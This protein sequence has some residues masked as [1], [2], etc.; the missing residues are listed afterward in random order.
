[1]TDLT[2]MSDIIADDLLLDR[3]GARLDAGS[4]PV[5]VLLGALAA[6]ADTPL[7][8]RTVRRKVG[9][10]HRYVGALA[11]LAVAASGAGVAAAVS[12]PD[13]GLSQADRLRIEQKM[14]QNARSGAPS[15]LLSRLGLPQTSTATDASGL[16]LAR[17]PDGRIVLVPPAVAAEL[18][19]EQ[20]GLV[21]GAGPGGTA[22][23]VP[24]EGAGGGPQGNPNKDPQGA[25]A[26]G[27]NPQATPQGNALGDTQGGNGQGD[28]T[29]GG[30]STGD[31]SGQPG[32]QQD[33]VSGSNAGNAGKGVNNGKKAVAPTPTPTATST[34]TPTP[35]LSATTTSTGADAGGAVGSSTNA[36]EHGKRWAHPRPT[37]PPTAPVSGPSIPMVPTADLTADAP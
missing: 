19:S 5:A 2:P 31:P 1:M 4:E 28:T 14:E 10:K 32:D 22:A 15:V 20:G 13:R 36:V 18:Y 35:T 34:A 6:H 21:L 37:Q 24:G 16:V 12:L 33:P 29:G 3:L 23:G 8:A 7:A 9:K 27:A 30:S 11:A 26:Q 17:Q 25:N